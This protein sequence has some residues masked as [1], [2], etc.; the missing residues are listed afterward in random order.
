VAGGW[1]KLHN[2]ELHNLYTSL[3]IFRVIKMKWLRGTVHVARMGKIIYSC[4]I[5][6]GKPKGK[7][8]LGI[9]RRKWEDNI[10]TDLN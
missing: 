10:R 8:P 5:L 7:R 4:D 1:R 9:S 3:N 6:V 2:E